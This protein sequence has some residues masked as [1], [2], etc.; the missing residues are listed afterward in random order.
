MVLGLVLIDI[1]TGSIQRLLQVCSMSN[2]YRSPGYLNLSLKKIFGSSIEVRVVASC[3]AD[4]V[5]GNNGLEA[6][7][8]QAAR[9]FR[10]ELP[11]L[12]FT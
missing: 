2:R 7:V 10:S 4:T 5:E 12:R 1:S 9:L 6:T 3:V 11:N 8:I